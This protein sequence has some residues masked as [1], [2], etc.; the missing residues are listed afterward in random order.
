MPFNYRMRPKSQQHHEP[1]PKTTPD[2]TLPLPSGRNYAVDEMLEIREQMKKSNSFVM[3]EIEKKI[4]LFFSTLANVPS[5]LEE[6]HY[7]QNLQHRKSYRQL[8]GKQS[9]SSLRVRPTNALL[10]PAQSGQSVLHTTG[11]AWTPLTVKM[12]PE[13]SSVASYQPHSI[14]TAMIPPERVLWVYQDSSGFEQGPFDGQRM[15]EWHSSQWLQNSLLIRRVDEAEF[16]PL[17]D[18]ATRVGNYNNPFLTPLSG[19]LPPAGSVQPLLLTAEQINWV[20]KDPSGV[21]QGPFD[22]T[23]MQEWLSMEWLTLDLLIRRIEESQ[24][25]SLKDYMERLGNFIDPF[26]VPQPVLDGVLTGVLTGVPTLDGFFEDAQAHIQEQLSLRQRKLEE[27]QQMSLH[28][29]QLWEAQNAEL[30]MDGNSDEWDEESKTPRVVAELEVKEE[31][32]E[33]VPD[34]ALQTVAPD[35]LTTTTVPENEW[36]RK[37]KIAAS[38]ASGSRNPEAPC[39]EKAGLSK[40]NEGKEASATNINTEASRKGGPFESKTVVDHPGA[41]GVRNA[42]SAVSPITLKARQEE[43]F[44]WCRHS[45]HSSLHSSVNEVELLRML[46]SLPVNEADSKVIISESIYASSTILDGRRFA[47]EFLRRITEVGGNADSWNELIT[48]QLQAD[49]EG[50]AEDGGGASG[51]SSSDRGSRTRIGSSGS[52]STTG[53]GSGTG[54][55][56]GSG[57]GSGVG[58]GVGS[59][60]GSG[61]S[62]N[63]TY[64]EGVPF[65]PVVSKH[66]KKSYKKNV[67]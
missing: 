20:Y 65:T 64:E 8:S 3:P 43:L 53:S 39:S 13:V 36:E 37:E 62:V 59:V 14:A 58:S 19:P 42:A 31:K 49:I 56:N 10:P 27:L 67:L 16:Y 34:S 35:N 52:G 66:H 50:T 40:D 11:N 23:R 51:N 5:V 22:G 47:D 9:Y 60:T 30:E 33:K 7:K 57:A 21:E 25:Y 12:E 28:Q 41:F 26:L 61:T 63:S 55:G 38:T 48:K 32:F 46:F 54:S 45:L 29:Q 18:L 17:Y 2:C 15:Q 24:Y 1:S 44:N 6:S 4:E